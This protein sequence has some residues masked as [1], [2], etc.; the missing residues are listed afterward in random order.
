MRVKIDATRALNDER[1]KEE[2]FSTRLEI[3]NLKFKISTRQM[4]NSQRAAQRQAPVGPYPHGR[5]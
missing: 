5:A 3:M 4:S 1:L 2:E